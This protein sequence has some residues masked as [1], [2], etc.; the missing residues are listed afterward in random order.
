MDW[1]LLFAKKKDNMLLLEKAAHLLFI[2]WTLKIF[3]ALQ[4]LFNSTLK[5]IHCTKTQATNG[6]IAY[7]LFALPLCY[8]FGL[9]LQKGIE[10]V[11]WALCFSMFISALLSGRDLFKRFA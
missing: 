7:I 8:Y 5:G 2:A 11:W 1:V 4:M 9:I 10:G 3:D 6:F